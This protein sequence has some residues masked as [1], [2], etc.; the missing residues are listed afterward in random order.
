MR[1]EVM[2]EQSLVSCRG[3]G[4]KFAEWVQ[5][6]SDIACSFLMYLVFFSRNIWLSFDIFEYFME[7]CKNVIYEKK[8]SMFQSHTLMILIKL[9]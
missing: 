1:A 3:V 2:A 4:S 7:S 9:G 6:I 8:S 5:I